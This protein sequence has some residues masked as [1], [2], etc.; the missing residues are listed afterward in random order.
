MIFNVENEWL[1][2]Y[3]S[4]T[5]MV[6]QRN[7][8][9]NK[10]FIRIVSDFDNFYN[11]SRRILFHWLFWLCLLSIYT[12]DTLL[13][14]SAFN[15]NIAVVLALRQVAQ[16]VFAFYFI[17]YW[18]I[19][20]LF[21][22]GRYIAGFFGILVPFVLAPFINYLVFLLF[23]KILLTDKLS[24]KYIE[25]GL[26]V[27]DLK[28][29]VD[30]HF[31]I[32]SFMPVV[33]R[34]MP[35]FVLKLLVSVIRYFDNDRKQQER[36][37]E[38]E[39][40]NFQ[41]EINFL[42]SQMN[43]H[44]FFNTLNN[45]YSSVYLKDEKALDQIADLSEIMQYTLYA[46]RD[47]FVPVDLVLRFLEHYINLEKNR[48]NEN[49]GAIQFDFNYKNME[50]F[51][52]VPLLLFPFLENAFKYGPYHNKKSGWLYAR[53]EMKN[54]S[55][56]F[57]VE[58]NKPK[59]AFQ[60]L[61]KEKVFIRDQPAIGGIGVGITVRRLSLLYKDKHQLIINDKTDV[62]SVSLKLKCRQDEPKVA[63]PYR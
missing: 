45:I 29:V 12:I 63:M 2:S 3:F 23:Y 39:R 26:F 20:R 24:L 52:I 22:Q 5:K 38:L 27:N 31:F 49:H 48:F 19:P 62:Y 41:L 61:L 28:S 17:C 11:H 25:L 30:W 34:T 8:Q 1:F 43:P 60:P 14:N 21:V 16:S 46:T 56:D 7:N 15:I 18:V 40:S 47:S 33:L 36:Q 32:V 35:A 51:M 57:F 6:I 55:L 4:I 9:A 54:G 10:V 58:N 44:Y 13:I 42:K 59:P 37:H 53:A 50:G